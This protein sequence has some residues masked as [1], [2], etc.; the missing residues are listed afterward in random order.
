LCGGLIRLNNAIVELLVGSSGAAAFA[1]LTSI[2]RTAGV[3]PPLVGALI[4]VAAAVL[5]LLLVALYVGRDLVLVLAIVLAPLA[6]GSLA[7]P[8]SAELSRTWVRLFGAVLFVQVV[9]A[10]LVVVSLQVLKHLDWL[11][12]FG[13]EL[14]SGLVLVTVLYLLL[15][16]PFMALRWALQHPAGW[17]A[18][19]RTSVVAARRAMAA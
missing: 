19:I 11:G 15:H 16:L 5:A 4:G 13:S 14:T 2:T 17:T 7:L 8:A 6:V 10:V 18:P 12:P 1:D 3:A 9:Q